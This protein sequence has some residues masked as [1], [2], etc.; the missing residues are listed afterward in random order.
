[1]ALSV[2]KE[3][4]SALF[5][6]RDIYVNDGGEYFYRVYEFG[7]KPYLLLHND[8]IIE[9]DLEK[10]GL[11]MEELASTVIIAKEPDGFY[12]DIAGVRKYIF[13][14]EEPSMNA[15]RFK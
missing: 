11:D 4:I 7:K 1:M 6:P 8:L 15:F 2:T 12:K 14:S 5:T 9:F 10:L 3:I 13:E